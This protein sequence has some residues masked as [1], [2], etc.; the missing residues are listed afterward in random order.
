MGRGRKQGLLTP[1]PF[2]YDIYEAILYK[3]DHPKRYT[4]I[5]LGAIYLD[6]D[7]IRWVYDEFTLFTT[8]HCACCSWPR[9]GQFMRADESH[10]QVI[11]RLSALLENNI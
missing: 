8:I 1:T 9:E 4:L 7:L 6:E 10:F 2:L 11:W 3:A 5:N